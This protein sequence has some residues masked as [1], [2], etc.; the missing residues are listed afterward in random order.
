VDEQCVTLAPMLA[1]GDSSR[2]ARGAT[3]DAPRRMRV[4]R[5]LEEES[6]LFCRYVRA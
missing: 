6:L 2:L 3:P 4:D 1:S 5:I